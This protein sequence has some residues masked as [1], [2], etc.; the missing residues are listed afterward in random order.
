MNHGVKLGA[1]ASDI[2]PY[3]TQAEIIKRAADIYRSRLLTPSILRLL[4]R[5]LAWRR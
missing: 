1:L 2:H 3:P 5:F 4:K